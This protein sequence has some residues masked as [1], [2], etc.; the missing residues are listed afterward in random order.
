MGSTA[1]TLNPIMSLPSKE[2]P[3]DFSK[4]SLFYGFFFF[5]LWG[6]YTAPYRAPP[7]PRGAGVQWCSDPA[8]W[9]LDQA[10][11]LRLG[12]ATGF[13]L[14]A[15]AGFRLSNWI[16]LDFGLIR[17]GF[18][19]IRVWISAGFHSLGFWLELV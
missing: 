14:L 16:L 18:G 11:R 10:L 5:S 9:L 3:R 2:S 4:K 19:L 6:P 12:E 1:R 8:P 13:W 17:F 7:P 15:S